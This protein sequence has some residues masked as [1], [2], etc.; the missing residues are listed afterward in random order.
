M[1]QSLPINKSMQMGLELGL[2]ERT[3]L[4]HVLMTLKI[5]GTLSWH[6]G[7]LQNQCEA[8]SVGGD[9]HYKIVDNKG[10]HLHFCIASSQ[11]DNRTFTLFWPSNNAITDGGGLL[12]RGEL[13]NEDLKL[14]DKL[15][16][17]VW[18]EALADKLAL[19]DSKN[20]GSAR[21]DDSLIMALG[22]I[23]FSDYLQSK[24]IKDYRRSFRAFQ[25][26]QQES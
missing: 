3:I 14:T 17:K 24:F 8:N 16:V 5:E 25:S 15:Q 1:L 19:E 13:S 2:Q 7:T 12:V 4:G 22:N 11:M 18:L 21:G 23:P 26:S 6:N 20:G 9:T 10:N